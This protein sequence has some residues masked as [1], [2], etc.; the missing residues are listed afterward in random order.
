MYGGSSSTAHQSVSAIKKKLL[1]V[2]SVHVY[3]VLI[4]VFVRGGKAANLIRVSLQVLKK[5]R[6]L[7]YVSVLYSVCRVHVY[8]GFMRF[9]SLCMY[10]GNSRAPLQSVTAVFKKKSKKKNSAVICKC[11]VLRM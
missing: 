4:V 8:A 5:K 1:Y 7:P 11:I 6:P 2:C 9:L 10:K 3:A